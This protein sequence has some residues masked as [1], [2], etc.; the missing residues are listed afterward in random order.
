M[1]QRSSMRFPCLRSVRFIVARFAVR[2]VAVIELRAAGETLVA[3]LAAETEIMPGQFHKQTH[4]Q[5]QNAATVVEILCARDQR[6]ADGSCEC[7]RNADQ[8]PPLYACQQQNAMRKQQKK[9]VSVSIA[10]AYHSD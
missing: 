1:D 5:K 9:G 3:C 4:E 6:R 7:I 2:H 10:R 8:K